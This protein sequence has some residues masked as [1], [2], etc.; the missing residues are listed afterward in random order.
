M[1]LSP[2]ILRTSFTRLGGRSLVAGFDGQVEQAKPD[3][4]ILGLERGQ[5][6]QY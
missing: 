2:S 4:E 1:P 6:A 3:L 5:L